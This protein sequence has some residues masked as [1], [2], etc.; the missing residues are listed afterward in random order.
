MD[1]LRWRDI[2]ESINAIGARPGKQQFLPKT[3]RDAVLVTEAR[4]VEFE[5]TIAR[6]KRSLELLVYGRP[7]LPAP[8]NAD[9]EAAQRTLARDLEDKARPFN[10]WLVALEKQLDEAFW[11]TLN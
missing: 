1:A 3:L 11:E 7:G 2:V 6:H 9:L 8:S 5:T 10:V 4:L